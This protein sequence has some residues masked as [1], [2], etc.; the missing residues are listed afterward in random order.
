MPFIAILLYSIL[1]YFNNNISRSF[2]YLSSLSSPV[3]RAL[4]RF[5]NLYSNNYS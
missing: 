5:R 4:Y 3:G 1:P 2:S